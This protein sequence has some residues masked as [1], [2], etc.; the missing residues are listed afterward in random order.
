MQTTSVILDKDI[1]NKTG[2][3]AT[4]LRSDYVLGLQHRGRLVVEFFKH[5][6]YTNILLKTFRT[7]W[8]NE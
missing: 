5:H 4:I 1:L 8:R 7:L 2:I 3:N 6:H